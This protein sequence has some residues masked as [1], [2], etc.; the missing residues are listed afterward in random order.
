MVAWN[1]R[2]LT[3][4][5]LPAVGE[6]FTQTM[7]FT[8]PLI[9]NQW[10]FARNSVGPILGMVAVDEGQIVG[11]YAL[12]PVELRLGREVVM[13]AQSVDTMTHPDYRSQGMFTTLANACMELAAD[14]GVEALYGF[15]NS[16]SYPGFIRKLNWDYTGD[17]QS[18]VR[19]IRFS[20]HPQIPNIGGWLANGLARVMPKG[21]TSDL[22]LHTGPPSAEVL[23]QLVAVW[24]SQEGVC[25]VNRTSGWLQWR[26]DPDSCMKYE[27]VVAF[28][29]AEPLAAAVWGIDMVK[30][31][32]DGK[33]AELVGVD[34]LAVEAVLGWVVR[35]ALERG[36]PILSTVTN[37]AGFERPLRCSGFIKG[38]RIPLIVRSLT[39]R[40]LGGNIHDHNSWR[41]I[42]ADLDTY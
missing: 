3:T 39:N 27:W 11:Q 28:R 1:I 12:W 29:G 9:H 15:P 5:D 10:K 31:N 17:I 8:R 7:G 23:E 30:G 13:G 14:R 4:E 35:Q 40:T 22:V 20:K 42:G 6:L 36:C 25:R 21:R 41:F 34:P 2:T 37:L 19:P 18:W 32:G 16:N 33:L 24:E 26:F 38:R